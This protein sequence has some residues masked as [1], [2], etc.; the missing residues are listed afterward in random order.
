M[1]KT[2]PKKDRPTRPALADEAAETEAAQPAPQ[3]AQA[4]TA[5]PKAA[6]GQGGDAR[7]GGG[8][9]NPGRVTRTQINDRLS[10]VTDAELLNDLMESGLHPSLHWSSD[11]LR[12]YA[13]E[14]RPGLLADVK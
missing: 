12:V 6:K 7:S 4:A 1:T 11:Q 8:T 2:N 14:V 5:A 3:A 13:I 9:E 10:C